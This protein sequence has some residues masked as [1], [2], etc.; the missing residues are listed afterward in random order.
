M[1][2]YFV[3]H[4]SA[5]QHIANPKKDEK[6]GLDKDGIQ[7]NHYCPTNNQPHLQPAQTCDPDRF[8]GRERNGI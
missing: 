2:I 3:R 8:F 4:A 5:G 7:L 1:I 6:R